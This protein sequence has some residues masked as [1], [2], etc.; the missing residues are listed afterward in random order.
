MCLLAEVAADHLSLLIVLMQVLLFS[1]SISVLWLL[2][3]IVAVVG[4]WRTAE[5]FTYDAGTDED[6]E[7]D[8]SADCGG[9]GVCVGH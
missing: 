7:A 1:G 3:R 8:Q 9:V 2:V 4:R 5:E 6:E